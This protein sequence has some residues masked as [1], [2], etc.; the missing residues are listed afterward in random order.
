MA[1]GPR[2]APRLAIAIGLLAFGGLFAVVACDRTGT[3]VYRGRKYDPTKQCLEAVRSLDVVEA[4]N[5]PALCV[6]V[7]LVQ[8][9]YDGG[10]AVYVSSTCP[11]YPYG[12][13]TSGKDPMCVPA[14]RA[15]DQVS[16]C[17]PLPPDGGPDASPD[18]TVPEPPSDASVD[19]SPD[20]SDG[21]PSDASDGSPSDA[22]DGSTD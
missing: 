17:L 20:A 15:A 1:S 4:T 8:T 7:C 13:D 16:G 19:A 3:Y 2:L 6:P 10:T 5:E 22:S 21:S 14:L 12:L 11:P 18:A 9:S